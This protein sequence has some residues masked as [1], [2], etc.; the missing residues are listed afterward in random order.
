MQAQCVKFRSTCRWKIACIRCCK[1]FHTIP[2]LLHMFQVKIWGY[3]EY[4]TSL[5][6]HCN[7]EL[8][9]TFDG[10]QKDFLRS[11]KT[12]RAYAA[13]WY[14]FVIAENTPRYCNAWFDPPYEAWHR[15]TTLPE[16]FCCTAGLRQ[17]IESL[18]CL[19]L[20]CWPLPPAVAFHQAFYY[21][22]DTRVQ[23]A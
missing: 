9:D 15:A 4:R 19:P 6:Y 7:A 17:D 5:I 1:T 8:L 21:R 11:M 20:M 12:N 22:L 13:L 10:L 3:L 14:I 23:L 18:C 16:F 2:E